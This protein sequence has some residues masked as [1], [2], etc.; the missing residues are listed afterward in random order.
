MRKYGQIFHTS[1]RNPQLAEV[2]KE[3]LELKQLND[4][5][6]EKLRAENNKKEKEK[7]VKELEKTIG[8]SFDLNVKKKQIQH[9]QLVKRLEE[10]Q[11]KVKDSNADVKKSKDNKFRNKKVKAAVDKL[12]SGE[13]KQLQWD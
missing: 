8:R 4:K 11:Q 9:E 1:Q 12:V 6:L 10:L 5:L 2:L 7:L 3:E 13:E